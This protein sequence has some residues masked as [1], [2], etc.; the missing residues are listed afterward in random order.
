MLN[1]TDPWEREEDEMILDNIGLDEEEE[2]FNDS[3]NL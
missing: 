1:N 2:S 3:G